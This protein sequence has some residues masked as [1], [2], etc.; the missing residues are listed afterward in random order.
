VHNSRVS[1]GRKA[2]GQPGHIGHARRRLEPDCTI[3]LKTPALC[4]ACGGGV[5]FVGKAKS[6]S[7][8]ELLITT[9]TTEYVGQDC[10]C[11]KCGAHIPATFPQ[12]A[13]NEAN[14]ANSVKTVLTY[15]INS[16]NMSIDNA[17][18]FLYEATGH[19]LKVSKGTAHNFL[20]AFSKAAAKD[21]DA[22]KAR[23]AASPVVN[24]DATFTS[25]SGKRTYAYVYTGAGDAL[26]QASSSKG[27]APLQSSPLS[28]YKGTIVHD[29]DISYYNFGSCNAEC[30]VHILRYLKGVCE[31]E[32]KRTWASEMTALLCE[33]NDAAKAAR[34][35]DAG[36]LAA[37]VLA[38]IGARYDAIIAKGE[39]EYVEDMQLPTKYRP[40]GITLL[41]RLKAYRD[42][43][44][45]FAHNLTVPFDNNLSERL[46]RGI[47][48]KLKQSG[49]F[50][51]LEHGQSYYCD[52]LSITQT[53]S[54]KGLEVLG[55]VR[56]VFD[57]KTGLLQDPTSQAPSQSP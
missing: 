33:A 52:F 31:N 16:C 20:A 24:S 44:L 53:A 45:L 57:G 38:N 55:V 25:V 22:L 28:D 14:Y 10:A 4:P 21:I 27:L 1:T 13:L 18:T 2:G 19:T 37:G 5:R 7:V 51:S 36:A 26:F 3:T 6:R 35:K 32:P 30:N 46:L 34:T 48:K 17:L 54:L 9:K 8:T 12:E 43:H 11:D 41:A 56:G 40:E 50:R 23:V 47:K 15:L 29:H 42:N 39:S 49:G